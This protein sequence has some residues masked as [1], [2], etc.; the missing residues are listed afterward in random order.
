MTESF[1]N[2]WGLWYERDSSLAPYGDTV[3]YLIGAAF[4]HGMA[5]EDWGCGRGWFK[6]VHHG[7]YVGIDGTESEHTDVVADLRE[8]KSKTDG[9]WIRGVIE[10]NPDW[11]LVLNNAVASAAKRIAIVIFTPDGEGQQLDYTKELEV[12]DVAVPHSAVMD[13]LTAA[14][15][16]LIQRYTIPTTSHYGEETV[17]LGSK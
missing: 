9:L 14:K 7:P 15:F 10:H 16:T 4:L 11:Q 17:F 3:T 2:R 6:T 1:L 8:Y 13:A 12:P 5:V